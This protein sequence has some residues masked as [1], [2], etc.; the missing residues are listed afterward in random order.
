MRILFLC[1]RELNYTR[2]QVLLNALKKIATIDVIGVEGNPGSIVRRSLKETFQALPYL[3][4]KHYDLIFVGFYGHALMFPVGLLARAPILFDAFISTYDTLIEDRQIARKTSLTAHFAWWVDKISCSMA[5]RVLLDTQQHIHYFVDT[6]NL[7]ETKFKVVPVGCDETIFF[8][9]TIDPPN[10]IPQVL[11][12]CTFLPLHGVDVVI[13]S[14]AM[15]QPN[16]IQ[17]QIIGNGRE[18]NKMHRLATELKAENIT[19]L[20]PLPLPQLAEAISRADI[21][22]GGH[23]GNSQKA[24][25]VIA[26]KTYQC[27]AM[28]KPVVV[29]D[30]PANRELL[31]HGWDAWF[32]PMNSPDALAQ[33]VQTLSA[34]LALRQQ[35]GGH[36]RDTF[37]EKAG[38]QTLDRQI[39]CIVN[40]LLDSTKD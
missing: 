21:C 31:T 37:I 22:L 7:P 1:G 8:P 29:G 25:R 12:Y 10:Q 3:L 24:A 28:G 40:Q 17:F 15:L 39:E 35:L 13:R 34:D 18:F 2:N 32:C 20:P 11:F 36:A 33:A 6:F 16:G 9:R 4:F 26:G 27:L 19:F 38:A 5:D 14:A 30:N 23:F